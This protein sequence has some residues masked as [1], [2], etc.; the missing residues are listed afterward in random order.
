MA[1]DGPGD[2]LNFPRPEA[3]VDKFVEFDTRVLAGG[4]CFVPALH[5]KAQ[6]WSWILAAAGA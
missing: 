1:H 3:G 4:Y 5:N 6:P 2:Q